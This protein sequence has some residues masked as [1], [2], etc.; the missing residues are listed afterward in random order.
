MINAKTSEFSEKLRGLDKIR[1][2]V[3]FW[4]IELAPINFIVS[5]LLGDSF[6]QSLA[7]PLIQ[8]LVA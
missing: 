3:N 2:L 1:S 7:D 5:T 8:A 6:F 4:V